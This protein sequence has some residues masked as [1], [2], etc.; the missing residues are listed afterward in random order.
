[1]KTSA[2]TAFSNLTWNVK[3]TKC[4]HVPH[5]MQ[6]KNQTQL[7]PYIISSRKKLTAQDHFYLPQSGRSLASWLQLGPRPRGFSFNR[8]HPVQDHICLGFCSHF[9]LW[10]CFLRVN[11]DKNN[12]KH[13]YVFHLPSFPLNQKKRHLNCFQ[14]HHNL[15]KRVKEE[16]QHFLQKV[17]FTSAE[18]LHA[19]LPSNHRGNTYQYLTDSN[20][21]FRL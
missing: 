14:F 12:L 16:L 7:L 6:S 13:T 9:M 1:M 19:I 3:E 18:I 5:Q 11:T 15:P 21:S 10:S 8:L 2:I 4:F 17:T 20:C